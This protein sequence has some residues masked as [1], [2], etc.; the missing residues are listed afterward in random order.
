MPICSAPMHTNCVRRISYLVSRRRHASRGFTLTELIVVIFMISLVVLLA[1]VNFFSV[2]KRSTFKGQVQD[3][4]STMQ[5]A[6]S[7]ASESNRRY[8]V[9]IDLTEQSYLLRQITTSDLSEVLDEEIIVQNYFGSNCRAAYV[10]F[11]DGDYTNEGRAKFRAGHSGWQYGGKIVLLD[12]EEK[13]Y[14]VV[15]NRLNR[16]VELKEGDVE[17]LVPK[18]EDEV[19]F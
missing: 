16:M 19:P 12:E 7:A 18:A 2:L 5:M 4:I 6:A 13:P 11:D 3:F 17:L 10:E 14:S 8:E 1:Q 15:I 9:I